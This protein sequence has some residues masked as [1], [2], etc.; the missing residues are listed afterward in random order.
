[1][2]PI[3]T[4]FL[5]VHASAR[6]FKVICVVGNVGHRHRHRLL[7][8]DDIDRTVAVAGSCLVLGGRQP[9]FAFVSVVLAVVGV[10]D[11][12]NGDDSRP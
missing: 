8:G 10:M 3:A 7:V 5:V 11:D 9:E 1:M 12:V 6:R 4:G 2:M